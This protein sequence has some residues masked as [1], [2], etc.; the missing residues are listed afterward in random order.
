[1]NDGDPFDRAIDAILEDRSPRAE[2]GRLSDQELKMLRVAQ[3]LRGNRP[4]AD[5]PAPAL[6]ES[7]RR[8][9][10]GTARRVS[11]RT[12]FLSGIGALA[13]GLI[14]GISL[15]R[16]LRRPFSGAPTAAGT[17]GRWFEVASASDVPPGAIRP[18]QI[19]ALQGYVLNRGGTLE[20][21]SRRCTHMGCTVAFSKPD[22]A[23][24]CPCHG[25]E[26]DLRGVMIEGPGGYTTARTLPPLPSI[27]VRERDGSIQIWT[28]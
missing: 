27:Q 1:M 10:I 4:G 16:L 7:V 24:V 8:G 28:V 12:A 19:G 9:Q 18:F 25:A 13:A 11:R 2:A 5:R 6:V 26:F 15:D 14:G 21:L 23:F 3:L 22:G 20:A 17:S